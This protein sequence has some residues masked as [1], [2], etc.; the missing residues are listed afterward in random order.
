MHHTR[1]CLMAVG[2][3]ALLPCFA[4]AQTDPN[5]DESFSDWAQE[6]SPTPSLDTPSLFEGD[7]WG[8]IAPD[9]YGLNQVSTLLMPPKF[10][11]SLT[12]SQPS[13]AYGSFHYYYAPGAASP[14]RYFA[15]LDVPNGAAL[16]G[17][18]CFFE[19]NSATND[20]RFSVQR[21]VSDFTGG[22]AARSST[23]FATESSSGTP[24]VS[25]LNGNLTTPETIHP[26]ESL[27]LYQDYFAVDVSDDTRFGGCIIYWSRQISPAP[28]TATF[29]DVPT[30]N[31]FFQ[32]V[33]ALVNSG[34]TSGCGAGNYCPDA[35]L[36]RGQMA[37]FLSKALGLHWPN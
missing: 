14:R 25:F 27:I 21:Y 30:S 5:L 19:D 26:W 17:Y 9:A 32:H 29:S 7:P 8:V 6:N 36:T 2:L 10:T 11:V 3:A 22:T 13:L 20:L 35:P 33:E 15:Q 37:V 18:T 28:T 23:T 31:P 16:N 24:G 12:A 34:I 4:A 1:P